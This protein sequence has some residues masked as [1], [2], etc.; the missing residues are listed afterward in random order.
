MLQDLSRIDGTT[1]AGRSAAVGKGYVC[2]NTVSSL[3][4]MAPTSR[5]VHVR[6]LII[7]I[8][9][10]YPST[11]DDDSHCID[12]QAKHALSRAVQSDTRIKDLDVS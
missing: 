12:R 1:S 10:R 11:D 3:S 7:S 9:G 2:A 5:P 6:G 4:V 8:G